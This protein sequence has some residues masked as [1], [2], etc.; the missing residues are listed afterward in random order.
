MTG[1]CFCGFVRY[2][3]RGVPTQRTSCHC[4]ICRR[5]TGAPHVAWFTVR[6][7]NFAI[8]S[9]EPV[10]F[11]SSDHAVR[12]FC[13]RCGTQLAFESSRTPDEIDVTTCSL[14]EPGAVPPSDHTFAAS[15]VSWDTICDGLDSYAEARP[16]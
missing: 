4:S 3:A 8:G 12:A 11:R 14:D 10:R 2:E 13:P 5:T 9:G 16:D 7:D 1:G 6:R 15:R